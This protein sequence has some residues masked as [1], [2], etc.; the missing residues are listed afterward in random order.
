M[1]RS[2]CCR[3]RRKHRAYAEASSSASPRDPPRQTGPTAWMIFFAARFPA[4]V[5]T[6]PPVGHPPISR[7]SRMTEGPAARWMA[8]STP[9]PPRR[10]LLAAF[11]TASVSC[12][13]MS[14]TT[15]VIRRPPLGEAPGFT[16][17]TSPILAPK[18]RRADLPE[19]LRHV[20]HEV[21]DPPRPPGRRVRPCPAADRL[22][23]GAARVDQRHAVAHH[24]AD[25]R[26]EDRV[27]GAA[28]YQHVDPGLSEGQQVVA[29]DL[30]RRGPVEPPLLRGG[31]NSGQA[32]WCTER[33]GSRALSARS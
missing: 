32:R 29:G 27:V 1:V 13:V 31:T 3:A 8:P 25:R 2:R 12:R 16:T 18:T 15:I 26:R 9:P 5:T 21:A 11:T 10:P 14:P 20:A 7:H 22:G 24:E 28:E 4:P 33:D 19:P 23:A 30:D 17:V 6:A